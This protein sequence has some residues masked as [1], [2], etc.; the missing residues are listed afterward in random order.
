MTH[1]RD[2]AI[3]LSN[4][5]TEQD[6]AGLDWLEA[7]AGQL[8][9]G[10]GDRAFALAFAAAPR[11]VGRMLLPPH[12]PLHSVPLEGW[13]RDQ[14]ARIV[15]LLARP[16]DEAFAAGLDCL[17]AQADLA[18]HVCLYQALSLLPFPERY[19]GRAA[20]GVRSNML[21]VFSAIAIGNPYPADW[22]DD[23]AWNQM[24][25]KA[26][27]VGRPLSGVIGLERRANP[28]LAAMLTDYARERRAAGRTVAADLWRPAGAF[29]CSERALNELRLTLSDPDPS[30]QRAAGLALSASKEGQEV[31]RSERPSL[32]HDVMAGR[33]TWNNHA[34]SPA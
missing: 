10:A 31:L 27:F 33:L 4:W 7:A 34:V 19:A 1:S 12:P 11:H 6:R 3:T 13:S 26:I 21:P 18:E 5:L 2:V 15:L 14:A 22:F 20:E 28:A 32:L 29:A 24:I 16:W 23:G 8:A 9:G 25:V 17:F 30:R